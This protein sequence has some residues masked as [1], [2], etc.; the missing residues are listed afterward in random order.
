MP[1]IVNRNTNQPTAG[2]IDDQ[3]NSWIQHRC[4]KVWFPWVKYI[5]YYII[6]FHPPMVFSEFAS[7]PFEPQA[8]FPENFLQKKLRIKVELLMLWEFLATMTRTLEIA[9]CARILRLHITQWEIP[10]YETMLKYHNMIRVPQV[11]QR[12]RFDQGFRKR[13][14]GFS[15]DFERKW[16]MPYLSL[17]L[18]KTQCCNPWFMAQKNQLAYVCVCVCVWD[19]FFLRFIEWHVEAIWEVTPKR[20]I[21]AHWDPHIAL[22]LWDWGPLWL[23]EAW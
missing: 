20:L 10:P 7:A 2:N 17:V 14:L 5:T 19:W 18:K 13:A 15:T 21:E 9:P 16:P 1:Q 4:W 8:S 3:T 22:P 23:T 12:V 6:C 11:V